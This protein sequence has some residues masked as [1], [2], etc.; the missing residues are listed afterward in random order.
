MHSWSIRRNIL[1]SFFDFVLGNRRDAWDA[2]V[3]MTCG[4]T[5]LEPEGCLSKWRDV[6]L[7]VIS[8][9]LRLLIS[10]GNAAGLVFFCG[11]G[12]WNRLIQSMWVK[13]MKSVK[14]IECVCVKYNIVLIRVVYL[15]LFFPLI[16]CSYIFLCASTEGL[17]SILWYRSHLLARELELSF[18]QRRWLCCKLGTFGTLLIY[19]KLQGYC[20][21]V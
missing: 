11:M 8:I 5:D 16:L 13:M 15:C 20:T 12:I 14:A 18:S 17:I 7:L 9:P 1:L 21:S 3:W 10:C 19:S 2:N 4:P 6:H